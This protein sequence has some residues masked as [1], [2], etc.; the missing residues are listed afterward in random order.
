MKAISSNRREKFDLFEHEGK[1]KRNEM[2]EENHVGNAVASCNEL[3]PNRMSAIY[4][5]ASGATPPTTPEYFILFPRNSASS[6]GRELVSS[7]AGVIPT[8]LLGR[9]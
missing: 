4:A 8:K 5:N 3:Q 2:V 9:E 7:I 6:R 1:E